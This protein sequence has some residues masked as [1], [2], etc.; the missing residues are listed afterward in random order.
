MW[1]AWVTWFPGLLLPSG[2]CP[3]GKFS[4]FRD[5]GNFAGRN[6]HKMQV[7]LGPGPT[8]TPNVVPCLGRVFKTRGHPLSPGLF[9]V[10]NSV[11]M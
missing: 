9:S 6:D 2:D 3:Q 8:E 1:N 10:P 4:A 11:G 5:T 7:L